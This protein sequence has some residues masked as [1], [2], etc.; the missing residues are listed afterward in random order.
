MG[1]SLSC[2]RNMSLKS[3]FNYKCANHRNKRRFVSTANE[4]VVGTLMIIDDV[5][6]IFAILHIHRRKSRDRT[7]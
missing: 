1:S 5:N 3:L 2:L 7:V 6:A 4:A